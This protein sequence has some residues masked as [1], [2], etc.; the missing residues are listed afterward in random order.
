MTK[1]FHGKPMSRVR[2]QCFEEKTDER[3]ESWSSGG[4]K[5]KS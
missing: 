5:S 3:I 2:P 1:I 4:N